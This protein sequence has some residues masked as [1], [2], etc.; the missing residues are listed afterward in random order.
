[1]N[2]YTLD[3]DRLPESKRRSIRA[4]YFIYG[5]LGLV[6]LLVVNRGDFSP[7]GLISVTVGFVVLLTVIGLLSWASLRTFDRQS[8]TFRLTLDAETITREAHGVPTVTLRLADVTQ[9]QD[10]PGTGLLLRTADRQAFIYIP[11]L[12]QDYPAL[13]ETLLARGFPV[14]HKQSPRVLMIRTVAWAALPTVLFTMLWLVQSRPVV[15][16]LGAVIVLGSL[17]LAIWLQRN[18]YLPRWFKLI[19]WIMAPLTLVLFLQRLSSLP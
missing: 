7:S 6:A 17:G 5:P 2:T 4:S 15:I 1:M 8:A 14:E 19:S 9:L 13:R 11:E 10:Y 3:P 18:T 12:V 16:A